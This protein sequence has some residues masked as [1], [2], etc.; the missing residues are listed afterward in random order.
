MVKQYPHVLYTSEVP[1]ESSQDAG[2]N[3]SSQVIA[4]EKISECREETDG[5]GREVM[6]ADQKLHVYTSVIFLPASCPDVSY[7]TVVE[8]R[9]RETDTAYRIKGGVIKFDRGQLHSRIWL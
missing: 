7:G 6:G 1:A 8:V 3:Y 9:N 4:L 2:G 5:R